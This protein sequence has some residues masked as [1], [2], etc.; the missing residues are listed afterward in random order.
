M[1]L[2]SLWQSG[3]TRM[4]TVRVFALLLAI[5]VVACRHNPGSDQT[6]LLLLLA[7][8]ASNRSTG[9]PYLFEGK[10]KPSPAASGDLEIS[11]IGACPY[12]NV[13]CWVE[14]YNR[15][16]APKNLGA[17]RLRT[18]AILPV[19]PYTY[20]HNV[21]FT[22]PPVIL[23]ADSYLILKSK[24][25]PAF[26]STQ[27]VHLITP[28]GQTPY[29]STSDFVEI[30]DISGTQSVDFVRFGG[31]TDNPVSGSF[32]GSAPAL[33]TS[34]GKSLGKNCQNS[35]GRNASDYAL[36]DWSTPG[37]PND[38]ASCSTD[39][40]NDGIPDCAE[41][42]G[43]SYAGF[44][45]YKRGSRTAQ[46]DIF[47][48]IDYIDSIDPGAI[49]RKD[50]MTLVRDRFASRGF[51]LHI[52]VGSLFQESMSCDV[53]I[54]DFNLTGGNRLPY[55]RIISL[56][57]TSTGGART[58]YDYKATNF[59]VRRLPFFH[60]TLFGVIGDGAYWGLGEI[61]AN[62]FIITM[63]ESGLK[64][65]PGISLNFLI[66]EQ[67]STFMH[68]LGHNLGLGHGGGD[69]VNYKPNY[70]SI[71]NYLYDSLPTI[72]SNEGDRYY[73]SLY[74]GGINPGG[75]AC[76]ISYTSILHYPGENPS[77]VILDYSNG[78][79]G[80]L[81]EASLNESAGLL[82]AGSGN[83]DWNCNG[84]TNSGISVDVN[85]DATTGTLSD[86]N[87][88]GN[89]NLGFWRGNA[90]SIYSTLSGPGGSFVSGF[91]ITKSRSDFIGNDQQPYAVEGP[92]FRR[93][94]SE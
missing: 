26:D 18:S 66:F 64:T 1:R 90:F 9:C 51:S 67:A 11:E 57:G 94:R 47:V 89:L 23:P 81:N 21:T 52:D 3:K 33:T 43:S 28:G 29:F 92:D 68:E 17:Y 49:P 46:R 16:T 75:T 5:Q 12:S 83:V 20:T 59:D 55:N 93:S 74:S 40:D 32:T 14:I 8:A 50:S 79:G 27:T 39:A 56:G 35:T 25:D 48:E 71:M 69:G 7:A 31:S 77:S 44:D 37:G 63:G 30:T 38:T 60:Y 10:C 91:D 34:T 76:Y 82:R 53:S 84:S 65:T 4:K 88:W 73:Y 87:D 19:S 86:Y 62:D 22:L 80:S 2:L 54:A 72:G 13:A 41:V 70:L 6:G 45:L 15:S 85:Q 36:Y 42:S 61:A 58:L 24:I 78:S